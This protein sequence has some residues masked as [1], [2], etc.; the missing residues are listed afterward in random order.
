MTA[1]EMSEQYAS[2]ATSDRGYY[3][4][5]LKEGFLAGLR[6]TP[7]YNLRSDPCRLPPVNTTVLDENGD[8]VE[9][10]GYGKWQV[11]SEYYE[12][13]I[14]V[15]PPIAWCECPIYNA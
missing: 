15:D 2:T 13:N 1:E 8:K 4:E 10:I 14:E 7:Y 9:Y 12:R 3:Y 6:Q 5:G 11:Y